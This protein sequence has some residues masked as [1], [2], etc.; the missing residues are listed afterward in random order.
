M[1][2]RL[3]ARSRRNHRT[4]HDRRPADRC[5]ADRRLADGR[6]AD[7]TTDNTGAC[8]RSGDRRGDR[9]ATNWRAARQAGHARR[10]SG[11]DRAVQHRTGS[12]TP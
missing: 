7:G 3:P 8:P 5:S 9:S 12:E 11:S 4:P 6:L 1:V 2:G 10:S